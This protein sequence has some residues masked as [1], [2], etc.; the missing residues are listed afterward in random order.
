MSVGLQ[1]AELSFFGQLFHLAHLG[2]FG[3]NIDH[4]SGDNSEGNYDLACY[5][6]VTGPAAWAA[7]II[8]ENMQNRSS[9]LAEPSG[10]LSSGNPLPQHPAETNANAQYERR[11]C[12][13]QSEVQP[14]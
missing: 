12:D 5:V 1:L 9:A 11:D 8:S 10:R 4:L 14:A 2:S 6:K 3:L 13:P 7:E